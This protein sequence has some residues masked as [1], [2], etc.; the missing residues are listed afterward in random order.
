MERLIRED[1][2]NRE[3][4]TDIRVEDL[5]DGTADIVKT[6]GMVGSDKVTESRTNVKTGYENES[7]KF[8]FSR[9]RLFRHETTILTFRRKTKNTQE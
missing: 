1:K 9:I 6:S 8:G 3:R 2:N 7:P 5:N 4:F